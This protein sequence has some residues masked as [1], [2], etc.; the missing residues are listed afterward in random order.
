V[1]FFRFSFSYLHSMIGETNLWL[2]K[3]KHKARNQVSAHTH[4]FRRHCSPPLL[5]NPCVADVTYV[6]CHPGW[7]DTPGVDTQDCTGVLTTRE[8]DRRFRLW[9]GRGGANYAVRIFPH[10]S[11]YFR[12]IAFS[13]NHRDVRDGQTVWMMT[14]I[15]IIFGMIRTAV[16][17][18]D[19][20]LG[21]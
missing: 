1:F 7:A 5:P 15:T 21:L 17:N 3:F 20:G 8:T 19:E 14:T 2:S 13:R 12:I 10:N 18:D 11:E 4:T 16:A 9:L 6:S